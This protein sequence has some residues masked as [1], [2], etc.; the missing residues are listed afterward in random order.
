MTRSYSS[1][2]S[3]PFF[4]RIKEL[5]DIPAHLENP[6]CRLL[7]LTG[8]GGSGK[9]RLAIEA[10][11]TVAAQFGHGTVFV[12][13]QPLTRSD[14]I[15][16]AIALAV[17][18]TFYGEGEP[19]N[20]LLDYLRGKTLLLIL[21]NFEHLLDGAELVNKILAHAPGVKVLATSRV[22][23]RQSSLTGLCTS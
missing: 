17:G 19:Q 2:F 12:G 8:Q 18:L 6:E 20:Q 9:T 7:T 10:A 3:T 16:P 15:V 22:A 23:P 1:A 11:K 5:V 21:D 14:L 4:G 13:L